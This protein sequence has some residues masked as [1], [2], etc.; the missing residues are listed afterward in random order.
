MKIISSHK[1]NNILVDFD[2]INGKVHNFTFAIGDWGTAGH[3]DKHYG[4]TPVYASPNAFAYSATKDLFALSR[5]AMELFV[6][7]K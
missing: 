4:G 3:K 6:P 5:M 1:P 7:G 2:L